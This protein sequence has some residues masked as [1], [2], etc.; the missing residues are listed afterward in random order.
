MFIFFQGPL[1]QVKWERI[2]LDEAHYIRNHNTNA[3]GGCCDL[4]GEA[5]WC[6][7]GTPV[8]NNE[9]D[10]YS[11]F[12]FLR[13]TPFNEL[14]I[15]RTWISGN[16]EN[17][18]A[19]L[20]NVLK[21]LI[22]RRTKKEIMHRGEL[23]QLKDKSVQ[24]I[25]YKMTKEEMAVYSKILNLSKTLFVQFLKQQATRLQEIFPAEQFEHP[26]DALSSIQP[27]KFANGNVKSHHILTLIVRLRQIC[28]HPGLIYK[29]SSI[30]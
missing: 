11:L 10:V 3:A 30:S 17:C 26:S 24:E 7:T 28:D 13:C 5:R 6:L 16:T 21:P 25:L 15:F 20:S 19:R 9:D 4:K 18:R 2:I 29:V 12:N 1:F 14:S 27:P 8:Q 23:P 22:L